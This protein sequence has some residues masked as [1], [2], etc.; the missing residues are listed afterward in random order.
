MFQIGTC[1]GKLAGHR[2]TQGINVRHNKTKQLLDYWLDLFSQC[3]GPVGG[4]QPINWPDRTSVQPAQCRS[5]LGDMFILETLG[6]STRY[7]LAGTKLCSLYGRELKQ[8]KFSEI[9]DLRDRRSAEN[10]VSR[11]SIDEQVV[12]ICS[13]AETKA[14]ELVN[15][16]TLLLPLSNSGGEGRRVLG[17]T[18]PHGT[19][20]N[21]VQGPVETQ[22]IRSV[23]V[24]RP[25]ESWA[26]TTEEDERGSIDRTGN[27][28]RLDINPPSFVPNAEILENT[29][30]AGIKFPEH[31]KFGHLVVID[32]GLSSD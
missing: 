22:S 21:R 20:A 16:E 14:Q 13:I 19:G 32:G 7:R 2:D 11:L 17:I 28:G 5:L 30:T 24:L 18:V 8:E 4:N 6:T 31:R 29:A 27:R 10:W 25:W 26:L 23:R 9:F 3:N 15:L 12:L 1:S